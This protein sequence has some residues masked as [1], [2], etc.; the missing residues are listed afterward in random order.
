MFGRS[1]PDTR[2]AGQSPRKIIRADPEC[3]ELIET[4]FRH[5]SIRRI[6]YIFTIAIRAQFDTFDICAGGSCLEAFS[7][8]DWQQVYN[9]IV[10]GAM[11]SWA[12]VDIIA[13]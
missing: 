11:H 1:R 8:I 6:R 10:C 3:S 9:V 2:S 7:R 12:A 13:L 5:P 4:R